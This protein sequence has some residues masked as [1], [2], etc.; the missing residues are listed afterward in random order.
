MYARPRVKEFLISK[1]LQRWVLIAHH[2]EVYPQF[3]AW[4]ARKNYRRLC[5]RY[6]EIMHRLGLDEFS[7]Y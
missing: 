2:P 4:R 7:A 6:P 3:P 5:T 1:K